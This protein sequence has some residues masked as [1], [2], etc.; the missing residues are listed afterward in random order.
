MDYVAEKHLDDYTALSRSVPY[1]LRLV[2]YANKKWAS[3]VCVEI[4]V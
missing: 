3:K 2:F 1:S 4:K